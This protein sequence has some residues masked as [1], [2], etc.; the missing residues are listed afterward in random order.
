MPK[1]FKEKYNEGCIKIFTLLKLLY[2]DRAYYSDVMAI[3]TEDD[4]EKQHVMLN[5]FLNTLKVFGLKVQKVNNKFELINNP[6]PLKFEIDDIKSINI[7]EK[8]KQAL[9]TSKIKQDLESLLN[10]IEIRFDDKANAILS[11]IKSTDKSDFSFY[12]TDFREQIEMCEKICQEGFKIKLIYKNKTNEITTICNAKQVIYDAKNAYLRIYKIQEKEIEDIT[13]TN[14]ISIK[15]LPVQT[16]N[17]ELT[18]TVIF[19]ISGH[20]AKAYTLKENEY[21]SEILEDGSKI[22]VNK[23]EPTINLLKRLIRY[24]YDCVI[25]SPK[26]LRLR[27]VEMINATLKN[28]E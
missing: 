8:F 6:F 4:E 19:K 26:E 9:P 2:E 27:M 28:Y 10:T 22:I 15:Q 1:K 25:L 5:K 11:S 12:Y 17:I 14:I 18:S 20:L 23:G 24:D 13:I 3:F 21:V 7:F 16:N